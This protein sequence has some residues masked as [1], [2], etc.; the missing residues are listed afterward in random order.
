MS[1]SERWQGMAPL[2]PDI[3]QRLKRLPSLFE[4]RGVRLAYLFGSLAEERQ[5][6]G[7]AQDV[8][9]ALLT[10]PGL[11]A[12]HLTDEIGK[13]LGTE[14]LDVVDL[15]TASP[16]L[17]FHIVSRGEL[18]YAADEDVRLEFEL[19]TV[20]QYQDTEW[21]RRQQTAM[22]KER[23]APWLSDER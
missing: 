4:E 17:R 18:L 21:L 8:D 19:E 1:V 6:P 5:A 12:Y 22:L 23:L 11:P 9:L 2:P 7:R 14:R 16:V 20:R 10:V 15:G 3:R 13:I